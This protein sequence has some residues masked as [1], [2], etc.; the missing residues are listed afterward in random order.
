MKNITYSNK[1]KFLKT[2]ENIKKGWAQNLHILAD[3]DNTLTK[4]FVD[5]KRTPSLLSVLRDN[6]EILWEEFAVDDTKLFEKFHPI[7]IDPNI[8]VEE[9][10]KQMEN[11]WKWSFELLIKYWFNKKDSSKLV[12]LWNIEFREWVLEFLKNLKQNSIPLV[13]ISASWI[14]VEPIKYFFQKNNALFDNIE[15]I[16][17]DFIWDNN[18]VAVWYKQ[19]IIHS[20]NK[21]ETVLKENVDI[22][23]KIKNRKNVILLWDSLGDHHMVDWFEY[24]NLINIWF[25]N[26]KEYELMAEYKKRYDIIITWDWSFDIVNEI[27]WDIY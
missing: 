11:W 17:N 6:F 16:S 5:W 15:I 14:W 18:W 10:N 13:I 9:K 7:E 22:Y 26:Q 2:L 4:A 3:F 24:D 20:F 1:E 27:L 23:E 19:P 21:S 25:L 12:D 8:Q